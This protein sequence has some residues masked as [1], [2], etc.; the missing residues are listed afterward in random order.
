M[1]ALQSGLMAA[2]AA[3]IVALALALRGRSLSLP[4]ILSGAV[5]LRLIA[6]TGDAQLSD[7]QY[8]Y[9]FEG[10]LVA[11]GVS[12]YAAAPADPACAP[13]R[14]SWPE[15]AAGIGH[16]EVSAAYPP[17]MQLSAA[18]VVVAA[19][20]PEPPE[21]ALWALRLFYACVDLAALAPLAVLARRRGRPVAA[22]WVAWGWCPQVVLAFAG[23]GHFDAL[24]IVLL[25]GALAL[26]DRERV[27]ARLEAAGRLLL[28]AAVLV[29]YLP[30]VALVS[31]TKRR[32]AVGRWTVVAGLVAL[33][34]A[35]PLLLEGG[36]QGLTAGLREYGLRWESTN[37]AYRLVEPLFEPE[38][39]LGRGGL[40]PLGGDYDGAPRDP[41]RLGRMAVG[42]AFAG[43]ALDGLRR[44]LGPT[45]ATARLLFAFALL[46][47][48]LHP[49]YLTWIAVTLGLAPRTAAALLVAVAPLL[50]WPLEGWH[51]AGEWSEPGWLWPAVLLPCM[52]F[53][54]VEPRLPSWLRPI[55]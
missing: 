6:L 14:E 18:A 22:A 40:L 15:L 28:A 8:R 42:L 11:Q 37:V 45:D 5:A 48:T 46:T 41:R 33:G 21:R 12:P 35:A 4:L 7:D 30:I 36:S 17:L 23:T 51:R 16:P 31:W 47:P 38:G 50:Y 49:W 39:P 53:A 26:F 34:S 27:N 13:Y 2:G 24:G 3:W 55:R 44:R 32:I 19:G 29:K 1:A 43:L 20:G 54:L 52:L 25:V 9:V 10:A